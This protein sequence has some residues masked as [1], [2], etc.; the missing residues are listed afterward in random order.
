M[1]SRNDETANFA[2]AA[3]LIAASFIILAMFVFF[4]FAI[5]VA[6]LT[7][8]AIWAWNEPRTIWRTTITPEEARSFVYCG[9]IG[10]VVAP[11][12][13]VLMSAGLGT[14]FKPEVLTYSPWVGYVF[15][16][17]L[18]S[19]VAHQEEEKRKNAIE[20]PEVVQ[21]ASRALAPP[22]VQAEPFRYASW[23]DEEAR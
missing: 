19:Y 13:V 9:L 14:A 15:G 1:S 22:P 5:I 16:A 12:L 17:L 8:V 4:V 20:D 23:D 21:P 10:A 6:V 18:Q 3:G 11:L 7:V 2:A